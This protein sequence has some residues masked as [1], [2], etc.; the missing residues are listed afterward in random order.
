MNELNHLI[1]LRFLQRLALNGCPL[2]EHEGS[3]VF[4]R[5]RVLRRLLQIQRLDDDDVTAKEKVKALVMHGSD[6][7][8]RQRVFAKYLPGQ[9]FTNFLYVSMHGWM[10]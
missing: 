10:K 4:Y 8:A 7:E 1:P 5:A 2:V 3:Q 9:Q 6:V